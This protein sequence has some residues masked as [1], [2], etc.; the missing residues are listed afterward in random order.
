MQRRR[1]FHFVFLL[2]GL[3]V[4]PLAAQTVQHGPTTVRFDVHHDVSPPLRDLIRNAPPPSLE[5]EEAE[6]VGRIPLPPGLSEL[7]EDPIRQRTVVPLTP[8]VSYSFEGLGQG[9]YGFTVPTV[10]PDTEGAVG[11]TQ[12]VQWVNYS[13]AMFDK[14]NGA[15]I[16]GPT[17]GNTLWSG[18]GGLCESTNRGDPI[19]IYDKLANRWVMS[20]LAF[21]LN[22]DLTPAPPFLECIAVST[23]SDALGTWYRYSFQYTDLHDYPKM[24]VWPDA[25]YETFNMF[26]GQKQFI[27]ADACAYDRTAMLSG[28]PATQICFQQNASVGG[29]LPA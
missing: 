6:P 14:S 4:A 25:Y 12:Y 2:F 7:S 22:A 17:A 21:N 16:A 26:N 19:A 1:S 10:P 8:L 15:L 23:S 9:P 3:A 28:L 20:Q 11:A 27:G 5:R 18:F 13:F 24:G 29:L